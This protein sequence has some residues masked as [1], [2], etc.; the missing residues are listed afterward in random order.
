VSRC[1]KVCESLKVTAILEMETFQALVWR[2]AHVTNPILPSVEEMGW[3]VVNGNLE[4]KLMSLAP[5]PE[6][7]VM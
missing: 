7:R 1:H 6:S 5:V 4:P 2:Q 3:K